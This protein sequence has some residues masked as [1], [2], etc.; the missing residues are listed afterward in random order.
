MEN[1]LDVYHRPHDPRFP[2]V[3][4]DETSKQL[5]REVRPALAPEPGRAERHDYE[6][7]RNGV[8]NLFLAFEPLAGWRC[9]DV[10]ENR[11]RR[12]WALFLV[13]L[14]EHR[15]HNAE[16]VTVVLDNL[17]THSGASFYEI[18]PPQEARRW[19]ERVEF[20]HTPKHGS[21]LNMA[22]G[23]FSVC[24]ASASTDAS[25]TPKPS[26]EKSTLG[27]NTATPVRSV[28][29]GNSRRNRRPQRHPPRGIG[30]RGIPF[31]T[32]F[33]CHVRG[34][35]RIAGRNVTLQGALVSPRSNKRGSPRPPRVN[36]GV[37]NK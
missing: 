26:S 9:V 30:E 2:V 10:T 18:F 22:E 27:S 14:L 21:W 7:Q 32:V 16:R 1:V 13:S 23:E 25:P 19:L 24:N 8:A 37:Q 17:N 35:T 3:C 31:L 29:T 15:Y 4:M 5:V 20:V 6:Y 12:D 33:P 28:Q 11:A 36:P 34:R